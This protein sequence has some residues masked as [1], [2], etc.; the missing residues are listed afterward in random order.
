MVPFQTLVGL[1]FQ[2]PTEAARQILSVNWPREALWLGLALTA[3]VNTLVLRVADAMSP[4]QTGLTSAI[5]AVAY[6]G[7]VFGLHAATCALMTW[8]G[9]WL[10]GKARFSDLLALTV[11][12]NALQIGLLVAVILLHGILPLAASLI[13]LLTNFAMLAIFML[14]IKEAHQFASIWRAIGTVFM[15]ALIVLFLLTFLVG[16]QAPEILGLPDHV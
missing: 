2:A 11:W 8:T 5:P 10:G 16:A 12:L 6:A 13:A 15:S 1:T 7:A 3:V 14:F 9:R 4:A